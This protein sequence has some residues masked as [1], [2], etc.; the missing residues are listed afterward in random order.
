MPIA[1]LTFNLPE[2]TEEFKYATNGQEYYFQIK[3]ID[4]ICRGWIKYGHKLKS[5]EEALEKVRELCIIE[6]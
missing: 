2:E 3:D 4:E 5:I 1:T 6:D